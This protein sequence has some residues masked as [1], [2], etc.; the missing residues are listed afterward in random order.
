MSGLSAMTSVLH[1]KTRIVDL[2]LGI[3]LSKNNWR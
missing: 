2:S 1:Q 3:S